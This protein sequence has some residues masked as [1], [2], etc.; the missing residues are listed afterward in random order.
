M[1]EVQSRSG[2]YYAP[3]LT[4]TETSGKGPVSITSVVISIPGHT[5]WACTS[6][7]AVPAGQTLELF[8]IMYGDFSP[9]FDRPGWRSS[10]DAALTLHVVDHAG[11][12]SSLAVTAPI[13]PGELPL[14]PLGTHSPNAASWRCSPWQ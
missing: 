6:G 9:T 11:R 5:Q 3:Q 13:T 4:L 8:P 10:G 14:P 12:S 7:L 1:L 2:W